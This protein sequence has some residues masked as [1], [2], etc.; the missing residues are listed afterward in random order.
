VA[1]TL[2]DTGGPLD[3]QA[4]VRYTAKDRTGLLSGTLK[5]RAG[6]P[7]A[8]LSQINDIAQ[9]RGRDPQGRVPVDLELAL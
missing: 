1:A 7:P 4:T 9:L 3:L 6:A 8:L 2:N 5:E